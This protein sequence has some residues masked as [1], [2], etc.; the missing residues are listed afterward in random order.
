MECMFEKTIFN[1]DISKWDV[2]NV[3]NMYQ[4]FVNSF[5][6]NDISKWQI[7]NDCAV[8]YMFD[9]CPIRK[10]YKPKRRNK[11]IS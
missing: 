7:N 3:T 8:R 5:F 10:E 2:R 4:M 11:R 6:D 9:N 1:G